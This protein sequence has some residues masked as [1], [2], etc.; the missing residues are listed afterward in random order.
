[1]TP[2]QEDNSIPGAFYGKASINSGKVAQG[3]C[4]LRKDDRFP[5]AALACADA[6]I[7]KFQW[8]PVGS[9]AHPP[10]AL[11]T[12]LT[13]APGGLLLLRFVDAGADDQGRRHM[14]AL[15]AAWVSP[16]MAKDAP[17]LPGQLLARAV[18]DRP[19][20]PAGT[21]SINLAEV[22]K[23]DAPSSVMKVIKATR[24]I[25]TVVGDA[26]FE[27]DLRPNTLI[28]DGDSWKERELSERPRTGRPNPPQRTTVGNRAALS[29]SPIQRTPSSGKHWLPGI[30]AFALAISLVAFGWMW[31]QWRLI[32]TD[33]DTLRK[34]HE[35]EIDSV[36]KGT[37]K[38]LMDKNSKLESENKK[39][40]EAYTSIQK[41]LSE[42][43]LGS[44]ASQFKSSSPGLPPVN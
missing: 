15:E 6:W 12:H 20:L 33:I 14:L 40:R 25:V 21:N 36:A 39:L 13:G 3:Y 4:W 37:D 42:L 10:V 24:D 35:Q 44:P 9:A 34:S 1:M 43:D 19:L 23:F 7:Q 16:T 5:D 27:L 31:H 41:L 11:L 28:L 18:V 29:A 17:S 30:L 22:S 38:A 2:D 8:K 32:S 26:T